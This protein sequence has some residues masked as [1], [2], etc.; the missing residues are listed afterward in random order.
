MVNI[1]SPKEAYSVT[2]VETHNSA[3]FYQNWSIGVYSLTVLG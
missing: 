3:K 2:L 1:L